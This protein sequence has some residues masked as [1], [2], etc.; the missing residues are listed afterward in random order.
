MSL[1]HSL[2]AP[3]HVPLAKPAAKG[4]SGDSADQAATGAPGREPPP[5]LRRK[6]FIPRCPED[7][8]DGG[9]FPEVHV[10]QYPLEMGRR[11]GAGG[12][13]KTLSVTVGADGE[14][15]YDAIVRQGSN[16]KKV[17]A[18]SHAE[19]LPKVDAL[20]SGEGLER[21]GA[22]AEQETVKDTWEALQRV[23]EA[24]ISAAQPKTLGP[25]PSAPQY[26]KYTPSQSGPQFNSGAKQRIIK[27][28]DMPS[29]PLEPPKFRHKKVPVGPGEPPV[30]I[31]HSPPRPVTVKDQQDWKIPP[32]V[33]NWKNAKGYTIPLDKRLAAD[34]RG[35]QETAV[36]DKFAAFTEA[37]YSA[38]HKAR[39]A[40][41]MRNKVQKELM[42]R[43]KE[44]KERELREL[45]QR[46]RLEHGGVPLSAR[47]EASGAPGLA[48]RNDAEPPVR[49][50]REEREERRRR[51]DIREERRRERER[52][53]RLEERDSRLGKK[54]KTTRDRERDV[55]EKVALGMAHVGGSSGEALY[56][57]RLFNQDKGMASGFGADD[58][59]NVY[60]GGLFAD[61]AKGLYRPRATQDDDVYGGHGKEGTRTDR[62]R[63]DNAFQGT[64]EPTAERGGHE[65]PVE[66][67]A[68]P[69]G[70][71]DFV[72]TVKA[73]SR[74]K[75]LD[76]IG[77]R[78]GMK[79][80][81]GSSYEE[82]SSRGHHSSRS[83]MQFES[84]RR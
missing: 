25:R 6:G 59:Y 56:D 15:S 79:A 70:L 3:A 38:E 43:E 36:S 21:P 76:D 75:P 66:F 53:R 46:A 44:K 51:D 40:L 14:V 48:T 47:V 73:S 4:A 2:P 17:V 81:A 5:Y 8:G 64:E 22:D 42:A 32:C 29:D 62:F 7:F 34:G 9:A 60:E 26:I 19:L 16:G 41:H 77:R 63:A 69:F 83:R 50:T 67:E 49:E 68:D 39:E 52:E 27:L 54:S 24:K 71:E 30:P 72:T 33:S 45:A 61:R 23:V 10:A 74:P 65:G 12:A 13:G 31:M 78:G 35:L 82:L 20:A 84:G 28:Q 80:A 55:T 57:T 18:A 58:S 11:D 1:L 37:L